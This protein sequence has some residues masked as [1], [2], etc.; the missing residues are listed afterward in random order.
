MEDHW[1]MRTVVRARS[2]ISAAALCMV[3]CASWAATPASVPSAPTFKIGDQ[4]P[5]PNPIEWLRGQP[6]VKF[7]PGHVYIVEFWATWCPPCIRAIPHLSELQAKHSG[8]LTVIGVNAES[9]LGNE[10]NLD[11]V[12][13]FVKRHGKEM[14]YTIAIDDPIKQSMS[15][16]WVTSTGSLGVPTAG[17]VDR[18]GRLV[19]IGYPDVPKGYS[20]DQALLDALAD[21]TDLARSRDLQSQTSAETAKYWAAHPGS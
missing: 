14:N 1:L 11:T 17:I 19:W 3:A 15:E 18:E 9:L 2:N 20:F 5:I 7:E 21:K 4:A 10:A 6:V 16:K 13:R 8:S 12:R